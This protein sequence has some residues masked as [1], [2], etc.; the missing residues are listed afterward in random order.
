M[1]KNLK[2]NE[3]SFLF[4]SLSFFKEIYFTQIFSLVE[5]NCGIGAFPAIGFFAEHLSTRKSANISVFHIIL[6]GRVVWE[7]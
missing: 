4:V 6:V 2:E 1:D 7:F 3:F 5:G